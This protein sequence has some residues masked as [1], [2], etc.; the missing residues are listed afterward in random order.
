[1]QES[2]YRLVKHFAK[3]ELCEYVPT[4]ELTD[5]EKDQF[6]NVYNSDQEKGGVPPSRQK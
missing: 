3:P 4:I 5:E 1:M 6:E 2:Q